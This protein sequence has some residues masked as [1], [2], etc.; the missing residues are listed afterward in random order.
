MQARRWLLKQKIPY[1]EKDVE[2]DQ[3]AAAELQQKGLAQGVPVR[4]VPVFEIYGHLLP[5]FD[6]SRI[7]SLLNQ[8][9]SGAG[10]SLHAI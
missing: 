4:G 9:S 3:A 1:V 6:P 10:E 5:G 7:I 2:S 8:G